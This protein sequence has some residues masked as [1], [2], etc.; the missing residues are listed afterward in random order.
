[1]TGIKFKSKEHE[2]F[3]YSMLDKSGSTDSYHR[4]FFYVM[5]IAPE[6]RNNINSL[7]NFKEDHIKP[8]GLNASWQTS[9]TKSACLLAF[10][11][12]NGYRKKGREEES[13][14]YYLFA[15]GYAPYFF[16][17]IKLRY[18]G[19]CKDIPDANEIARTVEE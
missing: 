18:P 4:G 5:G 16:E 7:F 19:F 13:T 9:G 14:P 3:Y 11:L 17:G 2:Y 6:M 8:E 1:M 12:W 15:C 10:N